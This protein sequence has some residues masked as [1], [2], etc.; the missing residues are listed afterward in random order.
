MNGPLDCGL[1][2]LFR[3]AVDLSNSG[4]LQSSGGLSAAGRRRDRISLLSAALH[5]GL[6]DVRGWEF[7]SYCVAPVTPGALSLIF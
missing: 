1:V 5:P 2:V 4:P 3:R 6:G 7:G